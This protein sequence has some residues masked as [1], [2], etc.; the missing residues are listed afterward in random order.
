MTRSETPIAADQLL[1]TPRWPKEQVLAL[2]GRCRGSLVARW[3]DG[4]RRR[5]GEEGVRAVREGL[6]PL[7]AALPDDPDPDSWIPVAAQILATDLVIDRLLGGDAAALEGLLHDDTVRAR[8]KVVTW[9]VRTL[10]PATVF[11]GARRLHPHL[12][13]AGAVEPEVSGSEATLRWTG[14]P[15]FGNPT[16]R[17]L[18]V[19]G[20]RI[21]LRMMRREVLDLRGLD[22]GAAAFGLHLRWR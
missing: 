20:N 15:L 1:A 18:Q 19:L 21:L 12:Y 9:V 14:S 7:S 11:R 22:T 6:G 13:D 4:C 8:D 3:A 5:W 10:G 17:V 16:F 2:P